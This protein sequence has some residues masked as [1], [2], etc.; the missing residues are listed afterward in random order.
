MNKLTMTAIDLLSSEAKMSEKGLGRVAKSVAVE[1]FDTLGCQV[2]MRLGG[3]LSR[4]TLS[5]NQGGYEGNG[6]GEEG[7]RGLRESEHSKAPRGREER[8]VEIDV[9]AWLLSRFVVV[10]RG[11]W[12]RKREGKVVEGDIP[13]IF[14]SCTSYQKMVRPV[15]GKGLFVNLEVAGIS[16]GF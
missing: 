14:R 15:S 11:R 8:Y 16:R 10:E 4:R 3:Q 9:D 5:E 6:V 2:T 12:S 1:G 13:W 7:C